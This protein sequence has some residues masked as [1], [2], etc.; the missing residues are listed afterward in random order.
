MTHRLSLKLRVSRRMT[1]PSARP[2]LIRDSVTRQIEDGASG[3]VVR[4]SILGIAHW[5]GLA[6][7]PF[8]LGTFEVANKFEAASVGNILDLCK[9]SNNLK[10]TLMSIIYAI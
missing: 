10:R 6:R 1:S 2:H 8:Y 7:S 5:P 9:T 3:M 4:G